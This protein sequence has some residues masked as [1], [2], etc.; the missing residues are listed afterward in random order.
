MNT[1]KNELTKLPNIGKVLAECL[2]QVGINNAEELINTGTE[3]TFIRLKTVDKDACFS[4]LC[5]IEGAIQGIRW[6]H[7]DKSRKSELKQF[8]EFIKNQRI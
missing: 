3:N 8:F 5:A 1:T 7:I 6:H 4:E 2:T